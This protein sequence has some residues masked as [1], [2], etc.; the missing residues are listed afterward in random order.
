MYLPSHFA[1]QDPVAIAELVRTHPLATL[2]WSAADGLSAEHVP[3]MLERGADD[4]EFGTLRGHVARA[5]PLW[6]GAA[7]AAVMAVFQ[8]AQA[9]VS[10]SWYP[11]KPLHGKVV[12]TWNYAVV[13]GH[14]AL[15]VV[16]DATWLRA[17]VGRLTDRHEA[18]RAQRWQVDDA[19]ADYVAQMVAAIVGIEVPLQ[20]LQG[21]WKHS[22][23]RGAEDRDSVVEGLRSGDAGSRALAAAMRDCAD[24]DP[25]ATST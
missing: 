1:Q 12:P 18:G 22:Q 6:R 21:K 20:R 16:E 23:N 4:G 3:L 15:R 11:G 17:L 5:N 7:G 14:G 8:G 25:T 19:P 13:H 10:P 2:V 9:Y 24:R